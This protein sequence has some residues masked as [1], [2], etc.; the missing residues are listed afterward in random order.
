MQTFREF[1]SFLR[2]LWS[3]AK[4]LV[5]GGSIFAVIAIWGLTT[6]RTV[7]TDVAYLALG[8]T[9]I[10]AGFLAWRKEAHESARLRSALHDVLSRQD[11]P[12]FDRPGLIFVN[13][14]PSFFARLFDGHTS[15]QS[16]KLIEPYMG[17]WMRLSIDV[18]DISEASASQHRVHGFKDQTSIF[19]Y[20]EKQWQEQVSILRS[21]SV[22][23]VVGQIRNIDR[24][25]LRLES[26]EIIS[27]AAGRGAQI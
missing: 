18:A 14:E 11:R 7:S 4:A 19:M 6:R 15:I 26:C 27:A 17:K 24:G 8:V 9:F 25:M 5:M 21:R 22:I 13:E 20:F 23:E 1:V 3:E 12:T 2:S 10:W 16:T